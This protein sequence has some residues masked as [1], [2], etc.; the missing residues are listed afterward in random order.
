MHSTGMYWAASPHR[1]LGRRPIGSP[2]QTVPPSLPV[3]ARSQPLDFPA[4]AVG[5][6]GGGSQMVEVCGCGSLADMLCRRSV[7]P[8]SYGALRSLPGCLGSLLSVC[9]MVVADRAYR[10]RLLPVDSRKAIDRKPIRGL[11]R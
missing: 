11:V 4:A 6:R 10:C 2:M 8:G 7:P 3:A 1:V 9:L 5:G